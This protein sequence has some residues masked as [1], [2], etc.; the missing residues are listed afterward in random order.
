MNEANEIPLP[1]LNQAVVSDR[2]IFKVVDYGRS[3]SEYAT[4]EEIAIF[5]AS[6]EKSQHIYTKDLNIGGVAVKDAMEK[7]LGSSDHISGSQIKAALKTPLHYFFERESG[8]KQELEKYQSNKSHFDLGT[9]LHMCI[10]EPSRFKRTTIE[11]KFSLASKDG[12][13]NL[14]KFWIDKI[15]LFGQCEVDGD[16]VDADTGIKAAKLAVEELNLD[17]LKMEGLKAYYRILKKISGFEAVSEEHSLIIS[18]VHNNYLRYGGGILPELLKHSKREISMYYTDPETGLKVRIR[19]D[20]IQFEENIGCNAIISV[21]STRSESISKFLYD[22]AK[23]EY[24]LSEGMYQSVAS[25]VTGRDFNATITIMLQTTAP[26]SV[27]VMVWNGEDIEIGKYRYRQGL[28]TVLDCNESG[29]YPGYDAFAEA[30]NMGL[31]NM[32]LPD[33]ITKELP[34]VDVED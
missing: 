25:G 32:K 29:K 8:W 20:A 24:H 30:G 10:L 34:P 28:Q 16:I 11:P 5:L 19:P 12:V 7:Y 23:Y 6:R 18:I 4:P 21:K 33:W 26:Y 31:I 22:A 14:I 1:D 17:P 3:L 13:T 2:E 9:F 27:A 15:E